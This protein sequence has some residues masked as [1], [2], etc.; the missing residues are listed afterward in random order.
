MKSVFINYNGKSVLLDKR[1]V[2]SY[3]IRARQE[4]GMTY[5]CH[6]E[7]SVKQAIALI[8]DSPDEKATHGTGIAIDLMSDTSTHIL[9]IM[10]GLVSTPITVQN[11]LELNVS[12]DECYPLFNSDQ[13]ICGAV[14]C[15][16]LTQTNDYIPIR[17]VED[18]IVVAFD[19][20][21]DGVIE[22][23][24]L[25][26]SAIIKHEKAKI[27]EAELES[28]RMDEMMNKPDIEEKVNDMQDK[29]LQ[30]VARF[31]LITR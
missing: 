13:R 12:L 21:V 5:I 31:I 29:K 14:G 24:E 10:D 7:T 1:D 4:A 8:G 30:Q 6:H 23:A 3:V 16:L 26:K 17:M 15:N 11:L 9:E 28:K 25:A 19:D 27:E 22:V 20:E 18:N 2:V